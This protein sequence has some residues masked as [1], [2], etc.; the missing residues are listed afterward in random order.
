MTWSSAGIDG[1]TFEMIEECAPERWLGEVAERLRKKGYRP[2]AIRVWIEKANR[3][4]R[5]L[6]ISTIRDRVVQMAIVLVIEPIFEADLEP[7]QYGY[8]PKRTGCGSSHA[9]SAESRLPQVD[10][11]KFERLLRHHSA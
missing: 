11:R 8:R 2:E 3:G 6:G 5:P 4:P 7:V 9:Q 1:Q 10:R